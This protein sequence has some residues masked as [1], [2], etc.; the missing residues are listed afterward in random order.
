MDE[1]AKKP[2]AE[3][4]PLPEES[5]HTTSHTLFLDDQEID[6]TATTGTMLIREE[7]DDK[8]HQAKASIFY[9]AY[10]K[11]GADPAKRPITFAF[12][13]GPGSSSVW[14]HLGLFG[15][16]R[17]VMDDIG[18]PLRPPYQLTN[19]EFSLLD[20]S[21]VVFIDPVSTGYS[22]AVPGEKPKQFHGFKKDV[23][24]IGEFIRLYTSRNGRWASPKFLG[25]ESYGTTRAAALSGFLQD[26]YGMFLNGLVLISS[27]LD[28]QT[29]Y[30][31]PNNDLP[32]ILFLPTY[33]AT[34]WYHGML[35]EELQT[36]LRK[37]VDE[38]RDFAEGA[39]ASA[40]MKGNR[41]SAET[42]TA[43]I[44][45]LHR[46]TGL[47]TTY[48]EQTN[49]RIGIHRFC[50]ELLREKQRTIGR[51]D[52]RFTGI[53]RD[54]AGE[55]GEFDPSLVNIQGT[56]TA[57]FN[58]YVRSEL[59]YETD[60]PYEI[61]TAKVRPW[62]YGDFANRYV[63]VAETLR[64]AMSKNPFLKVFVANG[65]YDMATPFM[66][67]EYTMSHLDLDPELAGNIDMAYY[68]AGHMMYVH[69]PSLKQLADDLRQFVSLA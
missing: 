16:R 27:V 35:D 7:D 33:A 11:D 17:V 32:Y 36:S 46:L 51:L 47:S 42:R 55:Y 49:L 26:K 50:K 63:D 54:S 66:A 3:T 68:E 9:V 13:G 20:V 21:D 14:L 65:Y 30:F 34:A 38:A 6:Y 5:V 37:T 29:V 25:G 41:I 48:L 1:Q 62:D 61:L 45:Q 28:F 43:I 39:Y 2:A 67:T 64:S 52:S 44:N 24:S 31:H 40:L 4:A 23:E 18:N 69:K 57:T 58:Q 19:N 60:L 59:G 15:P 56:Y 22:R 53:D 10:T 12:N 8:G